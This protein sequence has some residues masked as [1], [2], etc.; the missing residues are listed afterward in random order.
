M[1]LPATGRRKPCERNANTATRAPTTPSSLCVCTQLQQQHLPRLPRRTRIGK[2]NT[3]SGP[4]LHSTTR[5]SRQCDQGHA[6]R[7]EL[8]LATRQLGSA[9]SSGPGSPTDT[10]PPALDPH[11]VTKGLL[12]WLQSPLDV[13]QDAPFGQLNLV[14]WMCNQSASLSL[15]WH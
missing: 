8:V 6:S 11:L 14:L 7:P 3:H 15:I 1:P 9:A 4:P 5:K 13:V 12:C 2:L 10:L